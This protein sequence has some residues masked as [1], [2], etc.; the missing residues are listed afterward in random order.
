M[1]KALYVEVVADG[2]SVSEMAKL[3]DQVQLRV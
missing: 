3:V 1:S 2:L